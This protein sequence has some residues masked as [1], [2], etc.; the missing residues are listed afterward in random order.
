MFKR[1]CIALLL[2]L[3]TVSVNA[4]KG[5]DFSKHVSVEAETVAPGKVRGLVRNIG[6]WSVRNIVLRV[7]HHWRWD[8]GQYRHTDR[9]V[10]SE[11]VFSG[12]PAGFAAVHIPPVNIPSHARYSNKIDVIELTEI[13]IA[14]H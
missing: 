6:A 3:I 7:R 9:S 5:P 10:V 13:R 2:L 4:A 14:P 11:I 12:D 1:L 8:G